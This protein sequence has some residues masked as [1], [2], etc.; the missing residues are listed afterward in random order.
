MRTHAEPIVFA[1]RDDAPFAARIC[2]LA[3]VPLGQLEE[4]AFEGGEF[5][6]RPLQSVRGRD[7]IVLA[8]L[9]GTRDLPAGQRL[10]RLCFLLSALRDN[11]ARRRTALLP[12]LAFTRKDRRTQPRDPVNT[13]YVATLLEAAGVDH[14]VAMDVHNA[15]AIENAYRVP[16]D[17]LSAAPLFAA[18]LSEAL[19]DRACVVASPDI[20]GIKRAQRFCDLLARELATPVGMTYITK[21]REAG[22][23]SHGSLVGHVADRTV[24]LVD[25]LCASGATL[26]LAAATLRD[27]GAAALIAVATHAPTP[28]GI[29]ALRHS[30]LFD[31]VV[32]TNTVP[33]EAASEVATPA[34]GR[35]PVEVL[36]TAP[37]F[38][39]ALRRGE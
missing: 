24:L 36:D 9:A 25:D 34:P 26:I 33:S 8:S 4:R 39:S 12:Y 17:H 18:H 10:V 22:V 29:Q 15:A 3:D 38:A 27:A 32:I 20:G 2:A 35:T 1:C 5:K 23:I 28:D 16:F 6:L 21:R 30:G 37:L 13:R 7:V 31:R 14:L 11:R 19:R